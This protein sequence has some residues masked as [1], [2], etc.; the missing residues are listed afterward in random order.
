MSEG[1]QLNLAWLLV[2][3]R[4]QEDLSVEGAAKRIGI[5]TNT[6]RCF[7]QGQGIRGVYWI[8]LLRWLTELR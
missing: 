7:E 3:W 2:S 4:K 6:L 1:L 8:V 5:P